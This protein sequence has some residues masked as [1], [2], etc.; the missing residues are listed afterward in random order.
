MGDRPS[1]GFGEV[2]TT[3]HGKN[4]SCYISFTQK[5]SDLD[6]YFG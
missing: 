5:A 3:P 2:P 6:W 4:V 1:W